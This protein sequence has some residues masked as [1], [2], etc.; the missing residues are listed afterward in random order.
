MGILYLLT[1]LELDRFI[2]NGDLLWIWNHLRRT[3]THTHS[4]IQTNTHT[5]THQYKLTHTHTHSPIQTN[6]HTHILAQIQIETDTLPIYRI[7]GTDRH[8]K[9]A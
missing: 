3:H 6:T 4:P 7:Q 5:H 8:R 9:P 1:K 2:N